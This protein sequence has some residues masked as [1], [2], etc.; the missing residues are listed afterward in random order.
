MYRFTFVYSSLILFSICNL[1][2]AGVITDQVFDLDGSSTTFMSPHTITL[3]LDDGAGVTFDA[4]LSVSG[5][6]TITR[7]SGGLGVEGGASALINRNEWLT[8][9][10]ETLNVNGGAVTFT[11]FTKITPTSLETNENERGYLSTDTSESN[12]F[13]ILTAN[14]ETTISGTR[15]AFSVLGTENNSANSSFRIDKLAASF[16]TTAVPEP[17]AFLLIGLVGI[18]AGGRKYFRPRS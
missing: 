1:A 9:S 13:Q 14:G 16:S 11:G 4:R 7:T 15:L 10:M 18:L 5:S 12:Q 6:G 17:S 3:S 2:M 8:F